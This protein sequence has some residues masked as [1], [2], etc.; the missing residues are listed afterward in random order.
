MNISR[1]RELLDEHGLRLSRDLGQNFLIDTDL[2][3]ELARL[4][5]ASEGDLVFEVGT[6]LGVLTRALAARAARVRTVEIDSGLVRVLRAESLL[7]DN[8]EL[9]HGD[10]REID[11][12]AWIDASDQPVRLIA[13]LPYSVATPLLR[14]LLDLCEGL[15]DWSVMLQSEV[16]QRLVAE[17]GS[18]AYGSLT[19]LHRLVADVDLIATVSPERFFPRPKVDSSFVRI[20]PRANGPLHP[21]EL[22][23]VERL[24]RAAFSQRRKRV[25]NGLDRIAQK[26][27]PEL[28][29]RARR[30]RLESLLSSVGIDPSLRPE[31]IEPEA[32]LALSRRLDADLKD[33]DENRDPDSGT[34]DG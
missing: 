7:P 23:R 19:V 28:D 26:S 14:S 3:D 25:T 24:V 8:V 10:A 16:A 20:W 33:T 9:I 34:T 27:W 11:W 32:W 29:K 31:R 17:T 13:N 15:E 4:A 1:L 18:R 12:Q 21:G 30:E 22:L 6:G 2:A 5:G